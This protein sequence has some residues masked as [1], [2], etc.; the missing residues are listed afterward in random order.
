LP[1]A[2]IKQKEP[3][4]F[5]GYI[6]VMACLLVQGIG[7]GSYIAYGV[8]FKPLL[9][10][11]G[12]SRATLS[13]ASSMAFLLMGF[14]GILVGNL[15]DR[16]GPRVLMTVSG[17][18]FGCSYLLLSRIDA[19]WQLYL[20]YGL[21]GGIGLSAVDVI[22]LT[23]TAR[24]FLLRRG[25]MTGLVKA[26]TGAG[27]MMMPFLAGLL[28]ME[29]GWRTASVVIGIIAILCLMGAGQLLRRDPGQMGQVP[30]GRMNAA[31][32]DRPGSDSGLTLQQALRNPQFWMICT[33]NLLAAF[34]MLTILVHIVA[35]A[36]DIGIDTLKAAGILSTIGG[37]SMAGRLC[38][39]MAIDRI[40][41]R[42]CLIGCLVLLIASLLWLCTARQ[43]WMLYLF[44]AVYGIAHGGIFTLMSPIVAEFF[45]LRSHGAFF[46]I[47]A[48]T[49][50]V[51]GAAGPVLAGL[52]FD[53]TR[54]YQL[55]FLI[56]VGLAAAALI[57]T[58]LLKPAIANP[59][60]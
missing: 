22:P 50:T 27:Q 10:E 11:F 40:G 56:L 51:G 30:D 12:W 5:Y 48:F 52:I 13:G 25:M 58:L 32:G 45:G 9:N 34:C 23:T 47:V 28:I 3:G 26:G 55:I 4:F 16:F 29:L 33:I 7:I 18:F 46:G 38:V 39:G 2:S 1:Q 19:V 42:K 14:L 59:A 44:A 53:V 24:W 21:V 60:S 35:H 43:I 49:G 41:N 17:L 15:N 37:V 6:I 54:S 8:F 57:L 20:F 36:T 31:A